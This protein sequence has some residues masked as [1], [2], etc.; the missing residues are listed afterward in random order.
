MPEIG[1]AFSIEES[2]IRGIAMAVTLTTSSGAYNWGSGNDGP[3][4]RQFRPM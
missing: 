2:I 1:P 4:V 3:T